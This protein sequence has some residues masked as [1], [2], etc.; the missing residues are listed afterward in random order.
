MFSAMGDVSDWGEIISAEQKSKIEMKPAGRNNPCGTKDQARDASG[1]LKIIPV[2][3]KSR[4]EMNPAGGINPCG[5]KEEDRD[6][7]G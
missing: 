3:K 2:E 7:S 6:A 5:E 4:I 1:W